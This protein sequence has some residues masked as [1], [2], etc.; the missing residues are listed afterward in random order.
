MSDDTRTM[1][2]PPIF[3]KSSEQKLKEKVSVVVDRS[4]ARD[5]VLSGLAF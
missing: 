1:W 2:Y 3:K 4:T 5:G